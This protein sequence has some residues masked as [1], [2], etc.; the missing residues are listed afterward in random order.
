MEIRQLR[1][2]LESLRDFIYTLTKRVS[3]LEAELKCQA[4]ETALLRALPE[5]SEGAAARNI[6]E[7]E[8]PGLGGC[9]I[10]CEA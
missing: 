1:A 2:G 7:V 9:R 4:E 3:A 8:A 10:L 6:T 5:G